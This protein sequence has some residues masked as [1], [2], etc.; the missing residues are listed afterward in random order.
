MLSVGGDAIIENKL[1]IG[2]QNPDKPLHVLGDIRVSDNFPSGT[3]IDITSKSNILR[4]VSEITP[5]S[6][7]LMKFTGIPC[8]CHVMAK[9]LL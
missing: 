5:V 2:I 7:K 3:V 1:G 9:Q 8:L 4:E 6:Q